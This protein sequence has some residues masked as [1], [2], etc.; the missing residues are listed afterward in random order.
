MDPHADAIPWAGPSVTSISQPIDFGLFE[1]AAPCRI[2][3][4]RR[5]G[6]A[7]GATGGG[8]SGWLNVLMGDLAACEERGHL[9]HR[10]QKGNGAGLVDPCIGR[11]ATT[12][13]E[14]CALLADAVTV[15]EAR[16]ALLAKRRQRVW[17]PSPDMPALIILIDE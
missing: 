1:D 12:P 9:G 10:P 11:L 13:D 7:G 5:H 14:A 2:L 4:L 15:L 17:E 16:A 6:L 8:K 3:F